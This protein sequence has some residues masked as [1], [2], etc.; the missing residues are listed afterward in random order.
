MKQ[1]SLIRK[2]TATVLTC[3]LCCT[4][5][6]VPDVLADDGSELPARFDL[7]EADPPVLTTVK[8][9]NE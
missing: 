6:T 9:L 3:T 1:V 5:M 4:G 7:R 8:N 2:L